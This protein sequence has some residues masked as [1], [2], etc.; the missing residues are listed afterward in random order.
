MHLFDDLV[1]TAESDECVQLINSS[2]VAIDLVG[3]RLQGTA[4]GSPAFVF[5]AHLVQSGCRVRVYANEV[6]Q[7]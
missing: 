1:P 5:P 6:R 2:G 7:E 3:W 4:V